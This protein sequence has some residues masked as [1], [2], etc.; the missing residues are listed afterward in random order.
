MT[1]VVIYLTPFCPYCVRACKL[2]DSKGVDYQAIDVAG[3]SGLWDEMAGRSGR[4]T[5]PQ[6]FVGEHHVGGYDDMAALERQGELDKL[7]GVV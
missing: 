3:D 7:L 1:Q 4:D 2:L 5:V 6:V